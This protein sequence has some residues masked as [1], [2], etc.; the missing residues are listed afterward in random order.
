MLSASSVEGFFEQGPRSST[1]APGLQEGLEIFGLVEVDR[2]GGELE[3]VQGNPGFQCRFAVALRAVSTESTGKAS[4][5]TM[6]ERRS[7]A[8]GRRN[9]PG[10]RGRTAI[11]GFEESLEILRQGSGHIA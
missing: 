7:A 11:R 3:L 6:Q 5:R 10:A 9:E 8:V 1:A 4:G 2:E